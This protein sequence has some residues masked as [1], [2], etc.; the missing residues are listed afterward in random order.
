IEDWRKF[1]NQIRPHSA[2]GYRPPAPVAIQPAPARPRSVSSRINGR[3]ATTPG[4]PQ[5]VVQALGAGQF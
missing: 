4:L 5:Q 2:L 3:Q 1:Y